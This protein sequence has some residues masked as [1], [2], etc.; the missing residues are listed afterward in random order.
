MAGHI[1][2][3]I[4]IT[5]KDIYIYLVSGKST[6]ERHQCSKKDKTWQSEL[7][8]QHSFK[9]RKWRSIPRVL[10]WFCSFL[11]SSAL[12]RSV[13][14][15]L[16]TETA[17]ADWLK[18]HLSLHFTVP[19]QRSCQVTWISTLDGLSG[20]WQLC[21]LKGDWKHWLTQRFH[22]KLVCGNHLQISYQSFYVKDLCPF[23]C[24]KRPSVNHQSPESAL[25]PA[26]VSWSYLQFLRG[27]L[28]SKGS[29]ATDSWPWIKEDVSMPLWVTGRTQ[30]VSTDCARNIFLT[31]PAMI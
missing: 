11:G 27:S 18:V 16:P 25:F 5:T 3:Q 19:F 24:L 17:Q 15:G 7:V 1:C 8:N 4:F 20:A 26:Q 13:A 23:S 6:P 12:C 2:P 30:P 31:C 10:R 22:M 21:R 28:A 14:A 9:P 29:T